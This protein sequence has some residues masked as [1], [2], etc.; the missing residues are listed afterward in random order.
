MIYAFDYLKERRL[1]LTHLIPIVRALRCELTVLQ[2]IE[3]AYSQDV[4]DDLK[5]LQFIISNF[6]G[7]DIKFSYE[8]VRSD[9]TVQG[10]NSYVLR[11]KPDA[12]ALCSV[13]RNFIQRI[14]HKSI[15]RN[16]TAFCNYPVFV[17]HA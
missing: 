8:T 4:E 9:D 6:Y 15:I 16:I 2:V 3:E 10:I 7:D 11:N 1:P 13:H 5:E 12:L 17:F 14:F